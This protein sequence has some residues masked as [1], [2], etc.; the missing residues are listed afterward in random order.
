MQISEPR[1]VK[2]KTHLAIDID[3]RINCVGRATLIFVDRM[4]S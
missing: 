2:H 4:V 1:S 3:I